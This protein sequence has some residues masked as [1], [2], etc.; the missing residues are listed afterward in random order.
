MFSIASLKGSYNGEAWRSTPPSRSACRSSAPGTRTRRR[1]RARPEAPTLA[2]FC[3]AHYFDVEGSS[4]RYAWYGEGTRFLDISDPA[5]P[6][7]IAY[8]R[9]TTARLGLLHAQRLRLHRRRGR[10]I[11]ILKLDGGAKAASAAK[12][13][14]NAPKMSKKQVS[15]LQNTASKHWVSDPSTGGLCLLAVAQ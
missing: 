6:R 12:K 15:Y 1:A 9:P 10:G 14:V 5:N 2:D 11:D 13:E 3:S 7:Q 4:S 8:W